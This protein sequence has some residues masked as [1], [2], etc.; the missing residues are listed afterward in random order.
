MKK[1]IVYA[2]CMLLAFV[3]N[4]QSNADEVGL[5]QHAYGMGKKELIAAHMKLTEVE[6]TK[7][8]PLYDAYEVARKEYGKNRITIIEEYANSYTTLSNEKAAELLN[9]TL[10]NQTTFLKLQKNTFKKMAKSITAIRAAQ[11][12][13]VELYLETVI[14]LAINDEIPLIGEIDLTKKK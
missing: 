11:F 9:A 14:R 6:S 10:S 2:G 3:S 13:Q 4:A 8:W 7:F 12:V 5:I 1:I